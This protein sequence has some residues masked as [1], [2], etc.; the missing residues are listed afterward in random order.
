MN[1]DIIIS[2]Y[3]EEE[4]RGYSLAYRARGRVIKF[5][6]FFAQFISFVLIFGLILLTGAVIYL[7]GRDIS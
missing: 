4:V 3:I 2:A 7:C 6:E 1:L 5:S